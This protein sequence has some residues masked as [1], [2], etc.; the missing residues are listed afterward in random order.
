MKQFALIPALVV[1]L[2]A[3]VASAQTYYYPND[4]YSYG[5]GN[6]TYSYPYSNSTYSSYYPYN[7]DYNYNSYSSNYSYP[8]SYPQYSNSTYPSNNY[9]NPYQYYGY[10]DPKI[11]DVDGPRTLDEGELGR[12]EV[13][14]DAPR[15]SYV[16]ISVDWDDDDRYNYG[17]YYGYGY[18]SNV[19]QTIQV[20]ASQ[21][22][23]FTHAYRKEG[24]YDVEFR[25][26]GSD[27]TDREEITVRVEEQ[28]R[29]E[30]DSLNPDDGEPGKTITIRG[31]GFTDYNNT[32]HFGFGGEGGIRSRN[33]GE[34]IRFEIPEWISQCDLQGYGHYCG[35][36]VQPVFPGVY[37]VSVSNANGV[38]NTLYFEVED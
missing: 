3:G 30:I 13:E 2:F 5:Y 28:E 24:R 20:P 12:W 10:S 37:P 8:Y 6:N 16:T 29:L 23:S 21:I 7:Y 38:S 9:Y 4:Q 19:Q 25:V 35:T 31:S 18:G 36:S 22:V 26:R 17:S 27:K 32:V 33:N 14:I 1:L 15:G 11:E 34:E